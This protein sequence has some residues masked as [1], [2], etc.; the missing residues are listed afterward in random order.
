MTTTHHIPQSYEISRQRQLAAHYGHGFAL[1]HE[2]S[3]AY[4]QDAGGC[5]PMHGEGG[6]PQAWHDAD[7]NLDAGWSE[8]KVR[9][10][11]GPLDGQFR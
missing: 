11:G 4:Y 9:L 1:W 6:C 10:C 3:Q 7:G 5:Y 2:Q 8:F